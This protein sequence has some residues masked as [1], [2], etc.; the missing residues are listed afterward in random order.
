MRP[1][2][3]LLLAEWLGTYALV[4]CGT[5]AI[6]VDG[7]THQL[8]LG[9]IAATFG[10]LVV[11]VIYTFG[12]LSGAHCNPAVT[13]SFWAAGRFV[14]KRVP[15]YVVAQLLGALAASATLRLLV[16]G[17]AGTS[18]GGTQPTIPPGAAWLLEVLLTAGLLLV[19]LRVSAGAR[20]K[21]IIA[22]LAVGAVVALEA[23]VAGPLTGASMNPARSL[24]PAL[25]SGQLDNLWLY[26]TAPMAGAGLAAGLTRLLDNGPEAAAST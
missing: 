7:Q 6:V 11:V 19:I 15:A 2:W 21:G 16:P 12:D 17:A 8:G 20:E 23:L 3:R 13:V 10:L 4:A 25:V 26:L 9:G 18:L 5:A 22:G 14:G 24:G 1:V